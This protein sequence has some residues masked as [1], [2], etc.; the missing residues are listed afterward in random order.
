LLREF[1]RVLKP[2]GRV[3]ITVPAHPGLWSA[4][5][6]ALHHYR[7]YTRTGLLNAVTGAGLVVDRIT[8]GMFLP[9]IPALGWRLFLRRWR[10]PVPGPPQPG[11][12]PR[13]RAPGYHTDERPV[14][15]WLN[16][17]LLGVLSAE[18]WWM[19]RGPVPVGLSL[20]CVA[21]KP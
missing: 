14:P 12:D 21:R 16:G 17:L 7:R 15:G 3:L 5:D 11:E 19:R 13:E 20:M 1:Q 6:L 9:L 10:S 4:H 8:Y 18:A 2:G